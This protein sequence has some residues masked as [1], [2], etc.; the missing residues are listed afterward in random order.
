MPLTAASQGGCGFSPRKFENDTRISMAYPGSG[1]NCKDSR[2][3]KT[4]PPVLTVFQQY[5]RARN[6]RLPIH[7][8]GDQ[9]SHSTEGRDEAVALG[10]P[11]PWP[12]PDRQP[13][14]QGVSLAV[15]A[16]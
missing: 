1:W 14:R 5:G 11:M 9:A 3:L 4:L 16:V 7:R 13:T 12:A 15:Q 6:D 8:C 10:Q 2:F